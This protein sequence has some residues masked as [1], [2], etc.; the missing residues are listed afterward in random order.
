MPINDP[1]TASPSEIDAELNRLDRELMKARRELDRLVRH[2][3]PL[4]GDQP[5]ACIPDATIYE[6]G[7]VVVALEAASG[8]LEAEF[9]RRDG[10]TRAWLVPN[11]GGHV[12][13][14][15]DCHTCFSTTKFAWLTQYS[16]H[17]E[18]EIVDAAGE[19]ACTACYPNAPVETSNR[20]SRIKT[21][22]QL[23]RESQ[24]AARV[25]ARAAKAIK[26]PDGSPLCTAQHGLIK[27][28]LTARREYAESLSYA[29]CLAAKNAMRHEE[30]IFDYRRDAEIIL[31]ALAAKNGRTVEDMRA[32][33][34][35][36]VEARWKREHSKW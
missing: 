36:A 5:E 1:T 3:F 27:T 17:E 14:T 32:E 15:P 30:S 7:R 34:D 28:E 2:R 19:S 25:E 20:P 6:A 10:W 4:S 31:V 23:E 13:W 33:M 11:A 24:R 21:P 22:E 16:G 12:H 26:M 18:A 8:R 9:D 29:R 35:A